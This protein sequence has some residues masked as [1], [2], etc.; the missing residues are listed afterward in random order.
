[1]SLSDREIAELEALASAVVDGSATDDQLARLAQQLTTSDDARRFYVRYLGLSASLYD[2]ADP[3]PSAGA[4][5]SSG[6]TSISPP[7][8]PARKLRRRWPAFGVATAAAIVAAV[9]MSGLWRHDDA[10]P[11]LELD[12]DHIA[13]QITG[14]SDCRWG[15]DK[16]ALEPGDSLHAGQHLELSSG[17]AE[18]TFDSGAQ[19]TLEGPAA[20]SIDSAWEATLKHGKMTVEVPHEA[21]GF[22]AASATVDVVDLGTEYCMLV[23]KEGE[24][25]VG[26]L[27]GSVQATPRGAPGRDETPMILEQRRA[28]RFNRT[29]SEEIDNPAT[30]LDRFV[31]PA[32]LQRARKP[33]N[34]VRWPLDGA[35][36]A[37]GR[38]ETSGQP[39]GQLN[40]VFESSAGESQIHEAGRSMGKAY[41]DG[42]L[43]GHALAPGLGDRAPHTIAF[44]VKIS[45]GAPLTSAGPI[46]A[47]L[48]TGPNEN[49]VQVAQ[50][51]WN[52][53]PT[54]GP[55]GALRTDIGRVSAVSATNLRDGAWHFVA[56]AL[57]P[58]SRWQVR[59]Y[60]DGRL[61]ETTTKVVKKRRQ[62]IL[63]TATAPDDIIR[64]ACSPNPARDGGARFQGELAALAIADRALAPPEIKQLMNRNRLAA[65]MTIGQ[66]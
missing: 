41:F 17:I 59:Q 61:D 2:Y 9:W 52:T 34:I 55:L 25:D 65:E 28:R 32:K 19:I 7:A 20:L 26:V 62:E 56:V 15:G 39:A 50:I 13:A 43:A 47:W 46:V 10:L 53:D 4:L 37:V 22:R 54:Q 14:V 42:Q 1:M 60:V 63:P 30:M 64:V 57:M 48:T 31:K 58:R 38:A 35:G 27:Q 18:V 33:V 44:W 21:I 49:G 23:S 45:E 8:H 51:S 40:M 3:L 24:T 16:M 12:T 6:E 11:T 36:G 66:P 5:P 29:G